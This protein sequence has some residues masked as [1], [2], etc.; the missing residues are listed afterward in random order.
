MLGWQLEPSGLGYTARLMDVEDDVEV[1]RFLIE[2][3]QNNRGMVSATIHV[4]TAIRTARV[5]N[6]TFVTTE[7][8]T[9]MSGRQKKEFARR[10]DDLIEPPAGAMRIDWEQMVEGLVVEVLRRETTPIPVRNLANVKARGPVHYVVDYLVPAGRATILYGTGGTGKSVFAACLACCVAA[11]EDFVGLAT[12]P[13]PVLYLDWETSEEDV[14]ANVEMCAH[15][16]NIPT[17]EVFYMGMVRPLEARMSEVA[18]VIAER[19]VGLIIID[20]AGMASK[21]RGESADPAESALEFF[22]A[23]RE[24]GCAALVIDHV[25]GEDMRKGGTNTKP[26]G[27]IYKWNAARN[28][29][30]IR[31]SERATN[32]DHRVTLFHRKANLARKIPEFDVRYLWGHD[33]VELVKMIDRPYTLS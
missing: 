30:E 22:R 1:A 32:G 26:Y 14:A 29:F 12:A 25:S 18:R 15:G 28:A 31:A 23:L 8:L 7:Y 16:L 21:S 4:H 3:V 33:R 9:L 17:P 5:M 27:S 2:N 24:L 19:R 13:T 10:L 6:G 20:S 11:G